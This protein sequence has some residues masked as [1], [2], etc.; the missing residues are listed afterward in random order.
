MSGQ[1]YLAPAAQR[2]RQTIFDVIRIFFPDF[3]WAK[4]E[5][6]SVLVDVETGEQTWR[7]QIGSDRSVFS[8]QGL[9]E[10][11]RRRLLKL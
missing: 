2:Y 7:L 9:D 8:V 11:Q 1:F 3:Q 4:T 10:N 6:E 5:E